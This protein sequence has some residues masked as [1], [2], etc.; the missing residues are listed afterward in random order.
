MSIAKRKK[1]R[2]NGDSPAKARRGPER[3]KLMTDEHT[4]LFTSASEPA[5]RP[6]RALSFKAEPI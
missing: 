5:F 4:E 2:G 1:K 3:P 6:K